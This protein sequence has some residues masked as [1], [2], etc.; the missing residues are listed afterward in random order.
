MQIII[1]V[2]I[3]ARVFSY[4]TDGNITTGRKILETRSPQIAS[5]VNLFQARTPHAKTDAALLDVIVMHQIW[6]LLLSGFA[7]QK[8]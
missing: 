1:I 3:F 2:V 6:R 8:I 7:P 5:S 4:P